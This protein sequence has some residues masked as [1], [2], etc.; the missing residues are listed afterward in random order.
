MVSCANF[1]GSED[2]I[3]D[4][5]RISVLL[6]YRMGIGLRE[7]YRMLGFHVLWAEAKSEF[8][9]IVKNND[10]D[11]AIEWQH[12]RTDYTVRD[13]LRQYEKNVPVVLYLNYRGQP[14]PDLNQ[15]GYAD[16]LKIFDINELRGKLLRIVREHRDSLPR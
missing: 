2:M 11:I 10:F 1:L 7:A 16:T 6:S 14:P 3:I 4:G 13:I 15:L 9:E 5:R 12:G 8:I